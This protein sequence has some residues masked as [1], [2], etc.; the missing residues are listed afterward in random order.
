MTKTK[1]DK[2]QP[3][4]SADNAKRSGR[5]KDV[6]NPERLEKFMMLC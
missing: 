3:D 6:S 2:Y 4:S 1:L 5:P